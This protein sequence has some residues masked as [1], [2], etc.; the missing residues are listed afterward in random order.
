[1]AVKPE[2]E[3]GSG[4]GGFLNKHKWQIGG[5]IAGGLLTLFMGGGIFG[6]LAGIAV[7]LAIS[8]GGPKL[9]G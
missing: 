1:L 4:I 9:F 6:I 8:Y 7:S 5:A 3:E 2:K